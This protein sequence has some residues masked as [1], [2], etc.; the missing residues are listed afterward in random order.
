MS[1]NIYVKWFVGIYQIYCVSTAISECQYVNIGVYIY[2]SYTVVYIYSVCVYIYIYIY[3]YVCVC[4][5]VSNS[6]K[7][8]SLHDDVNLPAAYIS[9]S[10]LKLLGITPREPA[11]RSW[12]SLKIK[13]P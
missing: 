2:I 4:A 6:V 5:C 11:K 10:L 3:I 9:V 12:V 13:Y 7:Q 1:V 8:M